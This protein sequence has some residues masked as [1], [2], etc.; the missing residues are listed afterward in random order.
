[1]LPKT[2]KRNTAFNNIVMIFRTIELMEFPEP[3]PPLRKPNVLIKETNSTCQCSSCNV[4]SGSLLCTSC[5]AIRYCSKE[6]QKKNWKHH[7]NICLNIKKRFDETE[8]AASK[9]LAIKP[10]DVTFGQ[11]VED[12]LVDEEEANWIDTLDYCG[13]RFDLCGALSDCG[14]KNESKIAFELAAQNLLD[15]LVLGYKEYETKHF[16]VCMLTACNL[17]QE[18]YNLIR[19][20]ELRSQESKSMPYLHVENQDLEEEHSFEEMS[21]E[22][23]ASVVLLKFKRMRDLA[24]ELPDLKI[25]WETFCM[26]TDPKLGANS[27]VLKTK[28]IDPVIKKLEDLV[29]YRRQERVMKLSGQV[30]KLF[31]LIEIENEFVLRG[32][33]CPGSTQIVVDSNDSSPQKIARAER[34]LKVIRF[35]GDAWHTDPDAIMSLKYFMLKKDFPQPFQMS[36]MKEELAR[37]ARLEM[38]KLG[39]MF[40]KC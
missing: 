34:A 13:A 24:N 1:M 30:T 5:K 31:R 15:L 22:D 25:K 28:G 4:K 35:Y 39:Q 36:K 38:Q 27:H 29:Y 26:G 23:M 8:N 16:A 2:R 3:L 12:N 7:K 37:N 17:D 40:C 19:Y 10:D 11:Y 32:F 6:C 14:L 18:A 21:I 33:E 20:F 9:L